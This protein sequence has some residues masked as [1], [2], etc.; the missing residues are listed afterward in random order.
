MVARLYAAS[1]T[2]K[3]PVLAQRYGIQVYHRQRLDFSGEFETAVEL[4]RQRYPNEEPFVKLSEGDDWR[5]SIARLD[6]R[7]ISRQHIRLEPLPSD[8]MRVTNVSD[9]NTIQLEDGGLIGGQQSYE[10]ALPLLLAVGEKTIRVAMVETRVSPEGEIHR[11]AFQTVGPGERSKSVPPAVRSMS[12]ATKEAGEAFVPWLK[13]VTEMLQSS[14][15]SKEFFE[16][17]VQNIVDFIS[18]DTGVVLMREHGQWNIIEFKSRRGATKEEWSPSSRILTSIVE[19]K[20]AVWQVPK[21]DAM[22]SLFQ[23]QAVVAAPILNRAG[24]VIGVL[25]GDRHPLPNSSTSYGSTDDESISKLE[26]MLVET[27]ACGVAAGLDRIEQE[28]KVLAAQVRFEQFF[29]PELA[30]QLAAE[31][32][33]LRGR[34]ALI[35]LLFCD[36]RGFSRI[37]ERLGPA[38]TVE[39]IGSVFDALSDCVIAHRGVLVDYIGD[40]LMAMWGMPIE[41]P[42]QAQLACRAALA[43]W[44]RLPK[45]N[46][47]WQATLKEPISVGIGINTGIAQVGNTG[48]SR[49]FKYGP[50]GNTVNLASR[51]QG[52]TKYLK[53]DILITKETRSRLDSGFL[54]R[55]LCEVCV[56]NIVEPVELFELATDEGEGHRMLF[57]QYEAA[58]QEYGRKNFR[59]AAKILGNILDQYPDDGPAVVLLSRVVEQLV[60]PT[61]DFK[62]EWDLPGK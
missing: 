18:L 8:R 57:Q 14:A 32:E 53:G 45:L 31:P 3:G 33:M 62:P 7:Q 43:M 54:T 38:A 20:R 23:V 11:L 51:V 27:F 19:Q 16:R 22:K 49:K 13:A 5:V 60:N 48:S 47:Q 46:A 29:T 55:R 59:Q 26:A 4:G 36:I 41:Q 9:R 44:A 10:L 28:R 15:S 56:V 50:L 17:A 21:L 30:G 61:P 2:Q 34:E 25:Y 1:Q 35:T 40:E 58:L 24:E 12:S 37:S 39:W 6:E 42:D 52:A